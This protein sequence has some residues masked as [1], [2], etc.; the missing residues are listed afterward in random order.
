MRDVIGH[1]IVDSVV[2][3]VTIACPAMLLCL[4]LYLRSER[5][6]RRL[7]AEHCAVRLSAIEN[8]R[9]RDEDIFPQW[10]YDICVSCAWL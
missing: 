1:S 5:R 3:L 9:V 10:F 8:Q 7:D 2:S 6:K 4:H